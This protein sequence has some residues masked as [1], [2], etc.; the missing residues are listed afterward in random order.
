MTNSRLLSLV[1]MA[2]STRCKLS[3]TC[4]LPLH[5]G[6]GGRHG[7]KGNYRV[8]LA[9]PVIGVVPASRAFFIDTRRVQRLSETPGPQLHTEVRAQGQ[10]RLTCAFFRAGSRRIASH[11]RWLALCARPP[12]AEDEGNSRSRPGREVKSPLTPAICHAQ[13]VMKL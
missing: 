11:L 13:A 6:V 3:E 5:Y 9:R 12:A 2:G 4:V 8:R 1:M 10:H 7:R